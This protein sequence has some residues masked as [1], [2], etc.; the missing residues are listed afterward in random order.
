MMEKL[1]GDK[2]LS[3]LSIH[4]WFKRFKEG[5]KDLKEDKRS[6]RTRSNVNEENV[7]M[8]RKFI[9]K[10]PKSWYQR[11]KLSILCFILVLWRGLLARICH[12]HTE[13]REKRSW[14]LLHDNAPAYHS[15]LLTDFSTK[16][17]ILTTNHSP[18]S[19]DLAP[20]DFYLFGK[21]HLAMKGNRY[22]DIE[23]IQRS[24]TAILKIISTDEI[25]MSFHS[26]SDRAK[27]VVSPKEIIL[28]KMNQ[29]CLK[30]F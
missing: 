10:E 9:K 12:A 11:A 13:Y 29:L 24:M 22:A 3:R 25:K 5:R 18:Y 14:L 2:C 6:V 21:L 15:T 16:N 7:E 28:N 17:G 4:N 1:Y 27:S 20:C 26:L 23:T 30:H 19:P 8:L